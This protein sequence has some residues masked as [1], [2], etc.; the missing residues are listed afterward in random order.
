MLSGPDDDLVELGEV[1]E[2]VI[3]TRTFGG[4]PAVLTLVND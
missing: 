1:G 2:E 3:Y 4:T